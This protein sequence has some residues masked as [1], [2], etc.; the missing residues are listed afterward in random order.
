MRIGAAGAAQGG[1][2][3]PARRKA[4]TPT[5]STCR[6][7]PMPMILRSTHRARPDQV[8]RHRRPP[9]RCR[10]CS[11]IYT[12][13]DLE[14]LRHAAI[15]A[16]VQEPRRLRHEEAAAAGAADRQGALRRRSDRLRGGGDPGRRP[17]TPPRRS[18]STSSRCRS[19]TTP[20]QAVAHG[21]A[22]PV[23]RRAGQRLPRLPLRRQREGR[24]R[25]SRAPRTRSSSSSSTPG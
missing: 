12:G 17:R 23:R 6:T 15:G 21:R 4:A 9:R 10:A 2:Q 22:A 5:T 20:E 11:A 19:V 16:A 1:R 8:D 25:P 24:R 18:R 13:A 3:A 7:R 14:A